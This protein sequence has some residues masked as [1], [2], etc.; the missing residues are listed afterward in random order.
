MTP[1]Q[2]VFHPAAVE[3]AEAAA[4]WYRAL[5]PRA[6]GRFVAETFA[7]IEKILAAPQR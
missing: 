6:A 4:R 5:S 3:E 1:K 2:L 7:V